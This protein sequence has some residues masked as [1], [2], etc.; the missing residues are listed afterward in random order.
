ME[1]LLEIY[2][3][4]F[5]VRLV[6][7]VVL[8]C[9]VWI[10]LSVPFYV[11]RRVFLQY[12]ESLTEFIRKSYTALK[13]LV[14]NKLQ[15][16]KHI[17]RNFTKNHDFQYAFDHHEKMFDKRLESILEAGESIVS[18]VS[19]MND[20]IQSSCGMFCESASNLSD[21]E[22]VAHNPESL[23]D[24]LLPDKVSELRR[25]KTT[26]I[27]SVLLIIVLMFYNTL[28]LNLFFSE[29]IDIYISYKLKLKLSH[30]LAFLFTVIEIGFGYVYYIF[31][32]KKT[33]AAIEANLV[34]VFVI[35]CAAFFAVVESFLYSRISL[36]A[37][38]QLSET[39]VS[40]GGEP[41]F[42]QRYF[43]TPVGAVLVF[44]LFVLGHLLFS[45]LDDW[46]EATQN[47]KIIN[48]DIKDIKSAYEDLNRNIDN[49]ETSY[50]NVKESVATYKNEALADEGS[51]SSLREN[52]D[53]FRESI[54]NFI[55]EVF[56]RK[57][58]FLEDL[59]ESERLKLFY[60]HLAYV[61]GIIAACVFLVHME[62]ALL[63]SAKNL[64]PY[65][66]FII[67]LFTVVALL[68]CGQYLRRAGKIVL[69]EEGF[70]TVNNPM[71]WVIRIGCAIIILVILGH[72]FMLTS[73][74]SGG[75]LI[76]FALMVAC[77]TFLVLVGVRL[78]SIGMIVS[79]TGLYLITMLQFL[80]SYA[81]IVVLT[82]LGVLLYITKF[83]LDII[84]QPT[85]V[86]LQKD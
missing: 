39:I 86:F 75:G 67:S 41:E 56:A 61:V 51:V 38:G 73:S 12:Y 33:E 66:S 84:A 62:T 19:R 42:Y 9:I 25:A 14:Q 28:M 11:I 50:K 29:I 8:A 76:I 47:R 80:G 82:L 70:V 15:E 81:G 46:R 69:E 57:K 85:I 40:I 22:L 83:V 5:L 64:G 6:T 27:V 31:G 34:Q 30:L 63:K 52:L 49:L 24:Y 65:L 17:H 79:V 54:K 36:E 7:W 59:N 3:K 68:V 43:L 37:F 45:S 2:N 77:Y 21:F 72:S 13:E 1:G 35:V 26:F 48:K 44:M 71:S 16:A 60:T 53:S 58:Y 74:A 20:N 23:N 78:S 18:N 10:V 32:K 4:F 55:E